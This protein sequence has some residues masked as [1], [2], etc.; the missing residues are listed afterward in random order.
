MSSKVVQV[1]ETVIEKP[2]LV[3]GLMQ[4]PMKRFAFFS[5]A[6]AV[7]LASLQPKALFEDGKPRPWI[8]NSKLNGATLNW[9]L[10][11]LLVGVLSVTFI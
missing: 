7:T 9:V 8:I 4:S 6:T 2:L 3:L 11:S 1:Y 5:I 10:L